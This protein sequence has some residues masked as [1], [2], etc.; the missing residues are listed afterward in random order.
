MY[1]WF[2]ADALVPFCPF[3]ANGVVTPSSWMRRQGGGM[4]ISASTDKTVRDPQKRFAVCPFSLPQSLVDRL[5]A[6]GRD[7][8]HTEFE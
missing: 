3:D 6:R 1:H 4:V 5:S 8:G 7:R 2:V